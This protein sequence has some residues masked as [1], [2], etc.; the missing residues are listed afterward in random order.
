[1]SRLGEWDWTCR[2]AA[3]Y[4]RVCR[5]CRVELDHEISLHHLLEAV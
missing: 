3:D 1:M 4:D 5:V 2:T